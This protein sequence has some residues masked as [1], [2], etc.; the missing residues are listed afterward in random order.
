MR[1]NT[2]T[3][4]PTEG[5]QVV[6]TAT[7]REDN[8]RENVRALVKHVGG[9]SSFSEKIGK[10]PSTVSQM[11]G[12]KWTRA[13]TGDNARAWEE[14]FGLPPMSLDHT[15]GHLPFQRESM[16]ATPARPNSHAAA[17]PVGPRSSIPTQ[18]EVA[19]I[20]NTLTG[21]WGEFAP[22]LP[23]AKFGDVAAYAISEL[24]ET[25]KPPSH[26]SLRRLVALLRQK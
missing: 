19:T 24:A 25:G 8:R 2:A 9:T 16:G 22:E 17:A 12:N 14:L 15:P 7:K 3:Q 23:Q 26:T 21:I 6:S 10:K 18:E 4:M 11:I 5:T 1:R 13:I 20:V